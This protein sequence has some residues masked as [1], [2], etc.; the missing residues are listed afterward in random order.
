[1]FSL[2]FVKPLEKNLKAKISEASL[3][4]TFLH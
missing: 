3:L 2:F 4:K 1:L